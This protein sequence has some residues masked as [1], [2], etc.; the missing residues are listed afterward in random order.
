M[1]LSALLQLIIHPF[2]GVL[3][4]YAIKPHAMPLGGIGVIGAFQQFTTLTLPF[5]R[6]LPDVK[7]TKVLD[8]LTPSPLVRIWN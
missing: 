6:E 7:S 1:A 3:L 8:F 2:P 4:K 5:E